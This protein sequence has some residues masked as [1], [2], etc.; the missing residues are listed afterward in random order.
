MVS[1]GDVVNQ[2]EFTKRIYLRFGATEDVVYEFNKLS[3]EKEIKDYIQKFE[4]LR[5]LMTAM[6]PT[7]LPKSYYISSFISGL[8]DD[9]KPMLNILEPSSLIQA[10]EQE[11]QQE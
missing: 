7:S 6:N 2:E 9:V 4:E 10:F 1:N 5:S 8:K 11:K 3:Q